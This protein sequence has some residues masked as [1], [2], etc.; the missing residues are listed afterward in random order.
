M[1]HVDHRARSSMWDDLERETQDR[2]DVLN[3]E[4]VRLAERLSKTAPVN[5]AI[6]QLVKEAEAPLALSCLRPKSCAPGCL[7]KNPERRANPD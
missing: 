1:M 2:V 4:V 5:A 7:I 6:N 3:G